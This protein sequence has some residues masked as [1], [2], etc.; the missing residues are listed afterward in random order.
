[1]NTTSI[2]NALS[3][4]KVKKGDV[5]V[6]E[7]KG[8]YTTIKDG[9][10]GMKSLVS[11]YLARAG[12][13]SNGLVKD[14]VKANG[15]RGIVDTRHKVLTITPPDLQAAVRDLFNSELGTMDFDTMDQIKTA[16]LDRS[17]VLN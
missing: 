16:I 4:P 9:G 1:M 11:Y 5:V 8:S 7:L 10:Y 12:K 6:I 14:Y 17:K 3:Y 2:K 15:A 13:T